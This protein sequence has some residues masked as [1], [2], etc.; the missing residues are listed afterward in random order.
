MKEIYLDKPDFG[1]DFGI[2]GYEAIGRYIRNYWRQFGYPVSVLVRLDVSFNGEDW[3]SLMEY[4]SPSGFLGNDI[5]F[6]NDWWE[7]KRYIRLYG[8]KAIDLM[9]VEGGI[10]E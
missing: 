4:A 5:E 10:Y 1:K 8:I 9:E 3:F 6:D 7:G 2:T